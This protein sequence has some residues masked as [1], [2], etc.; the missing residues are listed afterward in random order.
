VD[1]T[2]RNGF[3]LYDL[4]KVNIVLG[5]NGCGKS[6]ILKKIEQTLDTD[7]AFGNTKYISPERGGALTF[8]AG[9]AQNT[10]NRNWLTGQLRKNQFTQFKQQTLIQ[11]RKLELLSLREIE[12]NPDLRGNNE[13]TFQSIVNSINSLLDNIELRR[14]GEDFKIYNLS[15]NTEIPPE[16]ISSGESEL[17][18]LGIECLVF[19]KECVHDKTNILFL[20]EP[21]AHLHPDLQA[22]LGLFI[23]ISAASDR[24]FRT[25][26]TVSH[27]LLCHPEQPTAL[28]H[29]S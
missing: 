16:N 15:D 28:E 5:K 4:S 14:E 27:G 6:T 26:P 21:D 25:I 23:N 1:I 12:S 29:T 24:V 2:N 3:N 22:R 9:V 11:F 8:D 13:Y 7:D 17:I 10:S 20:D 18:A 19:A